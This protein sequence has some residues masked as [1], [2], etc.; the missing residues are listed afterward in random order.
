MSALDS[1]H[2]QQEIRTAAAPFANTRWSV[3][4]SAAN[5]ENPERALDSLE[6]LCRAYWN[7]L[8]FYARR[9]GVS[10]HDAQDLTQEFFA[11]L[12][13]KEFLASVDR[14]KGRFRS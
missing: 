5:K 13:E 3:V 2:N 8:Y 6:C 12:L 11:R 7:P 10:P 9:D 4:L 1:G 14:G